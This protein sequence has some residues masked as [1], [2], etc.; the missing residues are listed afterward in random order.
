MVDLRPLKRCASA[1]P[2]LSSLRRT[3]LSMPDLVPRAVYFER[4]EVLVALV[5][6]EEQNVLLS[7]PEGRPLAKVAAAVADLNEGVPTPGS[8]GRTAPRRRP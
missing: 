7:R 4:C 6:A 1:L 5:F 8:A 2:P 3:I